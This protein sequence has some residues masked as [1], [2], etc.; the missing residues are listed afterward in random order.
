MAG[1][2]DYYEVLGVAKGADDEEIKKAYR[3]LAMQY[4]PDRNVGDGEA[5]EKFKEAAEAYEV[6]RDPEKRQRYD[7]Y[8]HAG[9]NGA[10]MPDFGDVQSI[11]DVFGDFFGDLFGQRG[12]RGPRPGGKI[13]IEV[14][15]DL[16]EAYRGTRKTFVVNREEVCSECSGEGTKRGTRPA[17]CRRCDGH[18]VVMVSQGFF[19]LQQ[20]C[21]GCGGHGVVITDPCPKCHG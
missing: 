14:E 21:P 17:R 11:F 4:H 6:L 8:G 12:R 13:D 18:G 1:K 19:R 2:R 5:E 7:R 3:R 15:L 16:I 10:N 20:T 9:L